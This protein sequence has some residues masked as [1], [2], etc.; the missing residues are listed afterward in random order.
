MKKVLNK[1]ILVSVIMSIFLTPSNVFADNSKH[2]N[3][4]QKIHRNINQHNFNNRNGDCNNWNSNFNNW[5]GETVNTFGNRFTQ[6][7]KV[8]ISGMFNDIDNDEVRDYGFFIG[9]DKDNLTKKS[10]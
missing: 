1:G 5:E 2:S 10:Q 4:I 6:D 9:N 7:N 3:E 8:I